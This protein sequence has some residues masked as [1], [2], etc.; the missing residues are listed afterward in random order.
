MKTVKAELD[1]DGHGGWLLKLHGV[2]GRESLALVQSTM[3]EALGELAWE[4]LSPHP[5]SV[6]EKGK[7]GSISKSID[8]KVH[9]EQAKRRRKS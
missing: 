3:A 2:D 6:I 5:L 8:A 7:D 4:A 9:A 1:I